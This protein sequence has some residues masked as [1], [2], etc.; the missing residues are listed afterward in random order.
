MNNRDL[1]RRTT[2]R[3]A[4]GA[5]LS[6]TVVAAVARVPVRHLRAATRGGRPVALARQTAM[7][8]AHVGFGFSL[9]RIGICFG[10]DRTTVRHACERI[11]DRRDDP[12][13][14]FGLDALQAALQAAMLR[15]D[16]GQREARR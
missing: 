5:R 16:A 7:Y 9:T 6:E 15:L 13:L 10:R 8:L 4:A 3:A 14:E 1:Q 12:A 2:L 11:E